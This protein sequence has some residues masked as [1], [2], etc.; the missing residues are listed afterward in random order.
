MDN[1]E[2]M[3]LNFK[4]SVVKYNKVKHTTINYVDENTNIINFGDTDETNHY[5][6]YFF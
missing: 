6:N 3:E 1:K 5:L 2:W 4:I